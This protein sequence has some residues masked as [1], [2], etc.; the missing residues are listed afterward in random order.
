MP[1][2]GMPPAG[3]IQRGLRFPA[4]LT[5]KPLTTKV[6]L[7]APTNCISS[8]MRS[9]AR[10]PRPLAPRSKK[11]LRER[12][13]GAISLVSHL[14]ATGLRRAVFQAYPGNHR[15]ELERN[16]AKPADVIKSRTEYAISCRARPMRPLQARE[17]AARCFGER[18]AKCERAE[19]E[20]VC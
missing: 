5:E 10:R 13:H 16:R 14:G 19:D 8:A 7:L 17:K 9:V 18:K 12:F 6:V 3:M 20:T 15:A 1:W 4:P 2:R 11:K